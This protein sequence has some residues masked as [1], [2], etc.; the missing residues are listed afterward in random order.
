MSVTSFSYW[1]DEEM[2]F[3]EVFQSEIGRY[4]L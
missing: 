4:A 3:P 1:P 2:G